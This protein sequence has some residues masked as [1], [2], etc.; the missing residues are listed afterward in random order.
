MNLRSDAFSHLQTFR[1][2]ASLLHL[3]IASIYKATQDDAS[4]LL[5]R[6]RYGSLSNALPYRLFATAFTG[7]S[8]Q[9]RHQ[10]PRCTTA[11][12]QFHY[13]ALGLR[14]VMH[15]DEFQYA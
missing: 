6:Q 8:R 7:F 11:P 1:Y 3:P 15:G 2:L 9:Q 5:T 14:F 13:L 4:S 10:P 12:G